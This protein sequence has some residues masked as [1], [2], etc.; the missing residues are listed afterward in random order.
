MNDALKHDM[1]HWLTALLAALGQN[2]VALA[3]SVAAQMAALLGEPQVATLS[4]NA[5]LREVGRLLGGA[6][7]QPAEPDVFI[8]ADPATFGRVLINLAVNAQQAGSTPTLR[9]GRD[10]SDATIA[11][12]DT[13]PGIPADR[14]DTI[15]ESGFSTKGS[16]GLGLSIVR[17]IVA[18]AGGTVAA[19]STLGQGTTI[20]VRWP[21][22]PMA[23]PVSPS[24]TRGPPRLVVLVE[25]EPIVRRLAER[26]LIAAG[27]QVAAFGSAEDALAATLAPGPTPGAIVAD[28]TLPGMDGP[29][30]IASM[31]ARWPKLPAVLVSGY[32]DSTGEADPAVGKTVFLAKP[33]ALIDLTVALAAIVRD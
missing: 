11:V 19:T 30:L 25:D 2:D 12:A 14:L 20:A 24:A 1:R 7:I 16:G 5:A 4:V 29:S 31:R 33:Y 6:T 13:G 9:A 32:T 26:A 23:A 21:L 28:R 8:R 17:S 27:W 3:R 10:G 18:A 15:F 22:A